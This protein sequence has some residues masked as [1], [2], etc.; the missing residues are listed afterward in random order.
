M[1]KNLT[2]RSIV[3][4][5]VV[6]FCFNS[7]F[8]QTPF[9]TE[10]FS[11]QASA[12]TNWVH[13]GTNAA[14]NPRKWQWTDNLKAGNWVPGAFQAP[15]GDTG[16]MY[17][18]SDSNDV[19]AYNITLTGVGVPAVATGKAD[20]HLR[21]YTY[22]RTF[23][24]TDKATVGI[25]T[26]GVNFTYRNIPQFDD[27]KD[28]QTFGTQRYQ[29]WI[30]IDVNEAD[31]AA[32]VWVQFRWQ[33]DYE[34]Y[35]KVDDLELYEYVAPPA[36][37]QN[38][39]MLI[40]DNFDSYVTTKK[41]GAQTPPPA[42]WSTWSSTANGVSIAA[43]DGIVST[44]QAASAPNSMKVFST[45]GAGPQDV[46][47]EL[48]NKTTG[49]YSLKWKWYVPV[50]KDGYYNFQN[51][52]PIGA[53]DWNLE[54]F[55]DK[56]GKGRTV[57]ATLVPFTFTFEHGKWLNI[58]HIIDLDNNLFKMYI[59]GKIVGSMAWTKNLG[60]I[61]I[62]G[63]TTTSLMYMDDLE[64]V[65]L[66]SAV[67]NADVCDVAVDLSPYF[68]GAPNV[69][70]TSGLQDNT[71]ATASIF[72]PNP[73]CFQDLSV[74]KSMWYTFS[75]N[76]N[77][78]HIETVK[79]NAT[80]YINYGPNPADQ[81][82]TQMALFSGNDCAN[83][84]PVDC[85]EDISASTSN[86]ASA[87][88]IQTVNGTNYFM[89][90]DGFN[91][92]TQTASG[93]YCIQITRVP[94]V[95]CAAGKVGTADG[96]AFACFGDAVSLS[97]SPANTVIPNVGPVYGVSWAISSAPIPA[98]TWPPTLGGAGGIFTGSYNTIQDVWAPSPLNN[99]S[100]ALFPTGQA[101]YFTP[102][103]VGG[104]TLTDPAV[105]S[106]MSNLNITNGCFFV[107][108]SVKVFLM[109]DASTFDPI[110]GAIVQNGLT[111]D[112]T[113]DGGPAAE[114]GDPSF[115]VFQWSNGATTEDITITTGGNYSV[116]ISDASGCPGI[117]PVVISTTNSSDPASV[118]SLVLSP[119]PTTG[120]FNLMLNLE[121]P[122]DVRAEI[123]NSIGQV[124]RTMDFGKVSN[125]NQKLNL[126]NVA[127]GTY[128]LHINIDG[129]KTYRSIVVAH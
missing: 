51:A 115:F 20:V 14:A 70:Q 84:L 35:W 76:G 82:D 25:S 91:T 22:Y 60:G 110:S 6:T 62:F 64:Y 37:G 7:A 31:N 19:G 5:F 81:G 10:T 89:M 118:K 26:D 56:G 116:T 87:I 23:T 38:P 65:K 102:V 114:Y 95:L 63:G 109:P 97:L 103:V 15:T 86:F 90:I 100:N 124:V 57:A 1:L 111:L 55:F 42:H 99:S 43:E 24:G 117:D 41:L 71:P 129:Q 18:D 74:D 48:G 8:S 40:C 105:N 94:D 72:D 125:I 126:E 98:G 92:G 120:A 104:A 30:D 21:F 53:G 34:Y 52:T 101:V 127:D 78:Y 77:R 79:C 88:D 106:F 17:F 107:G 123:V 13:A 68:G 122:S 9:W 33:G 113:P 58:E 46:V 49:R 54:I 121:T 3:A 73:S 66:P 69:A 44:E 32:Q 59:D 85:N 2:F 39:N 45:T 36:C 4:L 93:E 67:F 61:D 16:Y 29:G 27:L 11:D 28:E 12:T 108:E 80:N 50:D 83:L 119:N 47:L 112:L 128:F 96:E 75:G